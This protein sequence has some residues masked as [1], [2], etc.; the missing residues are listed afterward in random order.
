MARRYVRT[1]VETMQRVHVPLLEFPTGE[2][3]PFYVI[4][5]E[6][7]WSRLGLDQGA[8][9]PFGVEGGG[10]LAWGMTGSRVF[11][12]IRHGVADHGLAYCHHAGLGPANPLAALEAL[13]ALECPDPASRSELYV[14]IASRQVVSDADETFVRSHGV[15][16][17]RIFTYSGCF[18]TQFGVSAN[19][20]VGEAI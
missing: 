10:A 19:G 15:R 16:P 7:H 17:E 2:G 18:S 12:W 5:K 11:V 4:T 8:L 20:C 6:G 13:W 1:V 9:V 3:P 14:V